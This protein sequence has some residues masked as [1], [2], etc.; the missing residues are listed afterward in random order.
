MFFDDGTGDNANWLR[1]AFACW[2]LGLEENWDWFRAKQGVNSGKS[3]RRSPAH[4]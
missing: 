3:Q 2:T 1:L 4:Y